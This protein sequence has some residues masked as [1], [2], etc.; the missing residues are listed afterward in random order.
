MSNNPSNLFPA[1]ASSDPLSSPPL[2]SGFQSWWRPA[3][4]WVSVIGLA[5]AFVV[6]PLAQALLTY[7]GHPMTMPHIDTAGIM[8][9]VS[10]SIGLGGLRS[11]DKLKG[12]DTK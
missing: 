5:L 9:M 11:L 4:A 7:Y 3:C 6:F 1:P 12:T 10:T 8:G 2:S